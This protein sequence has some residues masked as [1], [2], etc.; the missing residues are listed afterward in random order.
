M[1]RLIKSKIIGDMVK[2]YNDPVKVQKEILKKTYLISL[3]PIISTLV[4]GEFSSL[5]GFVFGLLI[6][7]LLLRLKFVLI[8][9]S[10]DMSEAKANTFIRNR[11]FIEYIIYFLV[12]FVSARNPTLD[13]LAAAI[14]L[15]M[16]KF[17]VIAWV[18]LDLFRDKLKKKI[19]SYED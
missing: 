11:Y 5:L 16:I 9:R 19:E 12:L 7:T 17:T 18:V 14:G 10:L 6:S 1:I 8:N 13:F 2:N 3:V 4:M 15:F